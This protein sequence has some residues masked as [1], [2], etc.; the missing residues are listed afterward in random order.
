MQEAP[1][2]TLP[3]RPL[4]AVLGAGQV[5][6]MLAI[7]MVGDFAHHR[8]LIGGL[9]LGCGLLWAV[10]LLLA[11]RAS[12]GPSMLIVVLPIAI[13]MR[14]LALGA[15]PDLSDDVWRYVWEGGLVLEGKSPY[16]QA[17]DDP[18]LGPEREAWSDVYT[19]MNNK[20]VSAAYPPVTQ[21]VAA[22]VVALSGGPESAESSRRGLRIFFS[23]A[24]LLVLAPL[25]VLLR[26]RG[27]PDV[28]LVAW[29]WCPLVALEF[30]SSA[31]FDSLGVLLLF[32][33]LSL[34]DR[35]GQQ[36]RLSPGDAI[37][38][39]R[40]H[41]ALGLL[42]LA[43]AFLVKFLPLLAFPF[44]LRHSSPWKTASMGAS[45]ALLIVLGL[46]PV[47]A[48]DGGFTGIFDGLANYGLR[49]ESWNLIHH[50]V[51]P[52]FGIFGD[53]DGSLTDPRK[54]SKFFTGGLAALWILRLILRR[55]EPLRATGLALVAFLIISPTL[56]PW[57]LAWIIP[58]LAFSKGRAWIFLVAAS[59]L[60]YWPLTPWQLR[61]EWIEPAWLWPALALP[62]FALLTLD[63]A[64][65]LRA[66]R[67][68][69]AR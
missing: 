41:E 15:A 34:L 2:P 49:W 6:G 33:A 48:L 58:F 10:T 29:A 52:L 64:R 57:Y 51:E 32:L 61:G 19:A 21:A 45:L 68:P 11:R 44:V 43:A 30:G 3:N 24:D 35:H 31:H 8:A 62:F 26:R 46:L 16:S 59:P 56:H 40:S 65:D 9:M 27:L 63:I 13:A 4:F 54:L 37:K 17:P 5:L 53:R 66:E 14:V 18:S 23:L 55:E 36:D 7:L 12:A 22:A 42:A 39:S 60:L 25:L 50:K 1:A 69:H 28:L 20:D 38:P 67:T 47:L